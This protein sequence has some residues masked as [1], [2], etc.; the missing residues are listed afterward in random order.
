MQVFGIYKEVHEL[1]YITKCYMYINKD[2]D[3]K[4]S[5][6]DLNLLLKK[7]NKNVAGTVFLYNPCMVPL[8]YN[9]D[10]KLSDQ[11]FI[12]KEQFNELEPEDSIRVLGRA[13]KPYSGKLIEVKYLFNYNKDNIQPTSAL[14]VFDMDLDKLYTNQLTVFAKKDNYHDYKN[15][16]YNGKFIFFAWGHKF[17][18]H[19]SGITSYAVNI[20]QWALKQGKEIGFL[21]D[22]VQDK[23]DSFEY[24][25]FISPSAYGKLKQVIPE[26]LE[27]VFS[28]ETVEPLSIKDM[29]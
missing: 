20:A 17:D 29:L 22:G 18:K 8:G 10:E 15:I 26:A 3:E 19:H 14:E 13:L 7:K 27:K 2:Q 12:F 11:G 9:K 23:D 25:R 21:Y 24:V 16:S 4:L 1:E 6:E 28:K 5:V